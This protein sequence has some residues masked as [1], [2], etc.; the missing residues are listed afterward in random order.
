[1]V[2]QR[3]TATDENILKIMVNIWLLFYFSAANCLL[4]VKQRTEEKKAE[5]K[6]KE[7]WREYMDRL[8][9]QSNRSFENEMR[10]E[11]YMKTI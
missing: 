11:N 1:M 4:R 7:N 8:I 9:Y 2:V 6:R 10:L 5:Q 3:V